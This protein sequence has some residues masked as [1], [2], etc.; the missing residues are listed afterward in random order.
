[1]ELTN[2]VTMISGGIVGN[3]IVFGGAIDGDGASPRDLS[4][5]AGDADINLAG[6]VGGNIPLGA[7]TINS[8]TNF[9]AAAI[10]AASLLHEKRSAPEH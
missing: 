8:A 10:N 6:I 4:L 1:M 2:N 5:T 9:T 7:I 3:D